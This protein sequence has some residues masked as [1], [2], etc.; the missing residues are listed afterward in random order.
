MN[1]ELP[2]EVAEP[3]GRAE[4]GWC[5]SRPTAVFDG[6]RGGYREDDP[7]NPQGVY[8]RDKLAGERAVQAANPEA[9]IARVNFYGWSLS[10]RRSLAEFFFG[11][12]SAGKAVNGFTDVLF[13]PLV[14]NQ[15]AEILLEMLEKGLSGVYH[16]VSREHQSKYEFGVALAHRFGLDESLVTPISVAE[17]GLVAS[18]SP[19]LTMRVDKLEA[20]L[21]RAMPG[22]PRGWNGCMRCGP[23]A[24]RSW[25]AMEGSRGYTAR[26]EVNLRIHQAFAGIVQNERQVDSL[27]GG[28]YGDQN[29]LTCGWR[30][31]SYLFHCRYRRQP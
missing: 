21:G 7:P 3:A 19:N 15:L 12:L 16:A 22:R 14:A 24:A 29:R 11:N 31:A 25:C 30:P 27:S 20:A 17:S 8:A 6:E 13:C 10:G 9:V 1:A 28:S 2:G 26:S 4:R 18:R 23:R 5:T